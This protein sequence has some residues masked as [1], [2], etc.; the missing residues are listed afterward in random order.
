VIDLDWLGGPLCGWMAVCLFA[1][2]VV[3]SPKRHSWMTLPEYVRFGFLAT[4]A[5]F[6]WK[7]ANFAVRA[8]DMMMLLAIAYLVSALTVW[9]VAKSLPRLGW[10]RLRWVERVEREQPSKVPVM[11]EMDAVIDAH[12]AAGVP[13]A[14]PNEI[15]DGITRH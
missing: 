14:G 15:T 8:Q 6:L 5:M 4:G 12:A 3:S 2:H 9:I 1:I 11:M 10:D 7:A 13:V